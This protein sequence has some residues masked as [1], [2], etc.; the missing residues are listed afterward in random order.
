[1]D[2]S[3]RPVICVSDQAREMLG[4]LEV[5]VNDYMSFAAAVIGYRVDGENDLLVAL[6]PAEMC[7]R[8][9]ETRD[10]VSASG[11]V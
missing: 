4:Y 6:L 9:G 10:H 5:L 3:E 8:V 11:G 1:M 2:P 7:E